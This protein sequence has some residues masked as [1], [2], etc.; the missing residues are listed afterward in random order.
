[1]LIGKRVE[2]VGDLLGNLSDQFVD[3]SQ[4]AD[5]EQIE[6]LEIIDRISVIGGSSKYPY[7]LVAFNKFLVELCVIFDN[8]KPSYFPLLNIFGNSIAEF[9]NNCLH[10]LYLEDV[11]GLD[12]VAEGVGATHTGFQFE[13]GRGLGLWLGLVHDVVGCFFVGGEFGEEKVV[14]IDEMGQNMTISI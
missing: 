5:H 14:F 8:V 10:F 6:I 9:H 11:V 2:V 4:T 13:E 1:M 12:V 7:N 3:L